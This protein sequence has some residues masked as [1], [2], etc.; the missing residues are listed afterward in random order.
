MQK[1]CIAHPSQRLRQTVLCEGSVT[2]RCNW[3]EADYARCESHRVSFY[4]GGFKPLSRGG[5]RIVTCFLK[6]LS[7]STS[8]A[9]DPPVQRGA[10]P[11]GLS[12]VSALT[13]A[14]L[15][16][17]RL[18]E[19]FHFAKHSHRLTSARLLLQ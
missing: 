5:V 6:P 13:S 7:R 10:T 18:G 15:F 11:S 17:K 14:D 12:G 2:R 1:V 16:Q 9:N 3:R 8:C 4:A 19:N